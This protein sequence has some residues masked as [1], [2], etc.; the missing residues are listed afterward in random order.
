MLVEV[1]GAEAVDRRRG[2]DGPRP[3]PPAAGAAAYRAPPPADW[4]TRTASSTPSGSDPPSR[5]TPP[6]DLTRGRPGARPA[7]DPRGRPRGPRGAPSTFSGRRRRRWWPGGRSRSSSAAAPGGR[8][9]R[10]RSHRADLTVPSVITGGDC[11][12]PTAPARPARYADRPTVRPSSV[13]A[14]PP[15]CGA[16][17][18]RRSTSSGASLR[19]VSRR[20]HRRR[21]ALLPWSAPCIGA[22]EPAAPN[23]SRSMSISP[24]SWP[25]PPAEHRTGPQPHLR[26]AAARPDADV[27]GGRRRRRRPGAPPSCSGAA[28]GG[29]ARA[30]G[31]I[32]GARHLP[33]AASRARPT[34]TRRPAG[35]L[36]LGPGVRRRHPRGARAGAARAA[37]QGD[38]G[39]PGVLGARGGRRPTRASRQARS[40]R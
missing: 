6:V 16:S 10:P 32:P 8:D 13:A 22:E 31:R 23:A 1:G 20:N 5:P 30:Q 36:L 40:I 26:D 28:R 2:R 14:G 18:S 7:G 24:E 27:L 19:G 21:T 37:R 38:A 12:Q 15:P 29:A 11:V 4:E 33:T 9:R 25:P 34:W 3:G 35:H 17:R 39:R